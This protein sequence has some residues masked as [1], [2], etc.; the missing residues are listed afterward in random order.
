MRIRS[1][2]VPIPATPP[3]AAP[4]AVLTTAALQKLLVSYADTDHVQVLGVKHDATAAQIRN[5][6]AG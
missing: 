6:N 2:C 3:P 4:T 5:W 1:W